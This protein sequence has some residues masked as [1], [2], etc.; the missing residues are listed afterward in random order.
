MWFSNIGINTQNLSV[1]KGQ[2]LPK[3]WQNSSKI[4]YLKKEFG[5]NSF[6]SKDVDDVETTSADNKRLITELTERVGKL[7]KKLG[8]KNKKE[9]I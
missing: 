3:V 9:I 7:E 6:V 2:V 5:N 4:K 1:S 8:K